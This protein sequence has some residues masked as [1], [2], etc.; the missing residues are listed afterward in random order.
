MTRMIPPTSRNRTDDQLERFQLWAQAQTADRNARNL[1]ALAWALAL[2]G[3]A[4][5]AVFVAA[6]VGGWI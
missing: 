1:R 6:G 3:G 2:I 4:A 5:F